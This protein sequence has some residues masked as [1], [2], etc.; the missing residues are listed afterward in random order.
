MNW[1][2]E[3]KKFADNVATFEDLGAVK[4]IDFKKAD[5][6]HYR[7]R[8]IFDEASYSLFIVGD[9]G[10]LVARN[11]ENMTLAKFGDFLEHPDYFGSKVACMSRPR[12]V[13][14][15]EAAANDLRDTLQEEYGREVTEEEL[16]DAL[17][18]YDAGPAPRCRG[19]GWD[20]YDRLQD[21]AGD[22]EWE[23]VCD[24]GKR[25][26]NILDLYLC[27]FSLAREQLRGKGVGI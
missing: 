10:E 14:D 27:A 1:E 16:D 3:K 13:Y 21:I 15:A 11:P 6:G 20:G 19:M 25:Q 24:A 7:I 5:S 17:A 18:D 8:F 26:T 23:D 2:Y 22:L 4:I 12:W 9:L